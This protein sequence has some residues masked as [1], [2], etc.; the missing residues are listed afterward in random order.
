MATVNSP[1]EPRTILHNISWAT[2]E[3]LLADHENSNAARFTYDRGTLEI[4]ILS[5]KHEKPNRTISLL[6]EL[7][8]EEMEVDVEN[9]GSTTFK[10]EDLL[11]GF[12]P[13]TCFY[14]QNLARI[15]GKD[16]IDLT[17]DPPPDLIIEI[18][19]THSSLDKLP[20]YAQIGAPEVWRYDGT[21]LAIF[22]LEVGAYVERNESGVLPRLA[23]ADISRFIED[24]KSLRRTA[25]VRSVRGWA[26]AHKS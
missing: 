22:R 2:Y 13:D 7:I 24:S 16:E 6:V 17:V 12:E 11:R 4:M 5:A 14:I 18:D 15:E 19:I 20:I 9:F 25:W 21:K 3:G 8:A 1:P 26:R 23:S 10:R